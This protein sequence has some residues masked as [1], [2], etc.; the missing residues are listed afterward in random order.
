MV[1]VLLTP[2][3]A[4]AHPLGNFTVNSF[5]ALRVQPNR[6]LVD[7]VTDRAEI[8]TQQLTFADDPDLENLDAGADSRLEPSRLPARGEQAHARRGR[9][10]AS[11]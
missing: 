8:P 2:A 4:D 1:L 10:H 7:H 11:R 6:V 5:S 9:A 3:A